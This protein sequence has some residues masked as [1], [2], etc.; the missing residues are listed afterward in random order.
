MKKKLAGA[1][2][3]IYKAYKRLKKAVKS[4]CHT[5]ATPTCKT[6]L[7]VR[8]IRWGKFLTTFLGLTGG[9]TF[10]FTQ[11]GSLRLYSVSGFSGS[12]E[13]KKLMTLEN[14]FEYLE[15]IRQSPTLSSLIDQYENSTW[16]EAF[17]TADQHIDPSFLSNCLNTLKSLY[18][19]EELS[20]VLA[21]YLDMFKHYFSIP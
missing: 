6:N 3:Y 17:C 9:K 15:D 1:P 14:I 21:N 10:V 8:D 7:E 16:L 5:D 4:P 18:P 2:R 20:E 19:N 13:N 12:E 11:V